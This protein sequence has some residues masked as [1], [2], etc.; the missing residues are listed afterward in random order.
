MEEY[1]IMQKEVL[2]CLDDMVRKEKILLV[3]D[4]SCK[5]ENWKEMEKNENA[6]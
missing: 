2:K 3:G 1:E 4:F 6:G 5:G